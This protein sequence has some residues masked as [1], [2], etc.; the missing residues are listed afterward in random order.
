MKRE[1]LPH[2]PPL[3]LKGVPEVVLL[4]VAVCVVAAAVAVAAVL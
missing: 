1:R 2:D 4:I 3:R